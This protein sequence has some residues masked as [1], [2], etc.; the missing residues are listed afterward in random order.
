MQAM[1]TALMTEAM[2]GFEQR[3]HTV[4]ATRWNAPTPCGEWDVRTLVNHVVA[5]LLWV[6]P[7]LDGKTIAEV[8]DRF[9]GDILS[10]DPLA[11][12]TS[13]ATA[14]QAAASQP[15]TQKR[16]VH[17]SFGDFPGT[18]YL[19]QVTSDVVIHSW[20]LA[21]AVGAVD[22]LHPRLVEFVDGFL[23]PQVDAWRSAGA[24]GP[25]VEIGPDVNAQD[26]LL[27][28]TGR[29]PTWTS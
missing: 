20:D 5:E 26:R 7:L 8:G 23:S 3:L 4:D 21:R 1:D 15:G 13:A 16:T 25:A 24:F 29:S 10:D 17:L 27:A 14:A 6:P 11:A 22:R 28:Q 18:E 2:D 19:S 9:E 12:W